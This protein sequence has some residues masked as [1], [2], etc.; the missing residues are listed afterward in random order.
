MTMP[1]LPSLGDTN[2]YD[3]AQPVHNAAAAV[4][5]G[6]LTDAN[7][8]A[9]Y[10]QVTERPISILSDSR[11]DPTGVTM[12]TV[13]M[14]AV[15]DSAGARAVAIPPDV[16][17]KFDQTLNLNGNQFLIGEHGNA[18]P[19]D[20]GTQLNFYGPGTADAINMK[21]G[22]ISRV[23][24]EGFRLLDMRTAPTGGTGIRLLSVYNNVQL[25]HLAVWD[26]PVDSVEIGG[27]PGQASD[28]VDIDDLWVTSDRYGLNLNRIDNIATMRNIK[29]DSIAA[30]GHT[31]QSLIN[32][33]SVTGDAA[34]FDLTAAKLETDTG[35]HLLRLGAGFFGQITGAGLVMRGHTAGAGGDVVRVEN[36][37]TQAGI[38]LTG[39]STD[40]GATQAV[41]TNMVNE[42]GAG[43]V[44]GAGSKRMTMWARS[45]GKV[46]AF[47]D[48]RFTL[49]SGA[50]FY[51]GNANP[52]GVVTAPRG[53]IYI[54]DTGTAALQ[55]FKASTTGSTGWVQTSAPLARS[56]T[57]ILAATDIANTVNKW[58]GSQVYDTALDKPLW[59]TGATATSAWKDAA[60]TT[61]HT[62]A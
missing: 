46:I 18:V 36:T 55:Y 2:W 58:E 19:N 9:T 41:A 39:M 42:V 38:F 37:D 1:P 10:V 61:V 12:S 62:P 23:R 30:N 4:T 31:M 45:A 25:Y 35:C 3:W 49:D 50:G 8:T 5:T 17:L 40:N 43:R 48:G 47:S 33:D 60:G 16:T 51:T 24:L 11:V 44:W 26:F 15:L 59:S 54:R 29:G 32:L 20:G 53:S 13:G 7:L 57:Q 52:E 6:R 56:S 34:A 14:Q 27:V 21:A 22:P 28:C